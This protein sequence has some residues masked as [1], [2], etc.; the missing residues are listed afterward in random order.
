MKTINLYHHSSDLAHGSNYQ[1]LALACDGERVLASRRL[2]GNN[3]GVEVSFPCLFDW[4]KEKGTTTFSVA[5]NHPSGSHS[6]T[7]TDMTFT[8]KLYQAAKKAGIQL[9]TALVLSSNGFSALEIGHG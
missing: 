9:V 1:F 5:Y 4:L 2:L 3:Q 6:L 7:D 8:S